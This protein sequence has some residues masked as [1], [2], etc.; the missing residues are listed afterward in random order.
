MPDDGLA[1]V[2]GILI[3]AWVFTSTD[4]DAAA[5]IARKTDETE[6]ALVRIE[7]ARIF[8]HLGRNQRQDETRHLMMAAESST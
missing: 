8:L 2:V 4:R 7:V 1:E 6:S 3:A 5:R